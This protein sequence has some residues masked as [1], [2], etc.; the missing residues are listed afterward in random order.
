MQHYSLDTDVN[1][2]GMTEKFHR[3]IYGGLKGRIRLAV[4][5][6]DVRECCPAALS[7]AG[8]TPLEILDAGCGSAPFSL[9]FCGRGHSFTLC[10][11][12]E[13]MMDLA[14]E[15]AKSR[16]ADKKRVSDDSPEDTM[17]SLTFRAQP[18][19]SLEKKPAYDLI[20][21]HALLEWVADGQAVVKHLV[22]ML[23][24]GGILSLAFYNYHALVFQH[25]LWGNYHNVREQS[26]QGR[27]GNL[28]PAHPRRPEEVLAWIRDLAGHPLELL[29]RSGIRVFHDYSPDPLK[30]ETAPDD[31]VAL[32]LAF[33]RRKPYRDM[34][35]YQHLVFIKAMK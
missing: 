31:V 23:R 3:R 12:S 29:C 26:F 34:G 24:P 9:E 35:R 13:E 16:N 20:L 30:Q 8:D 6:R 11:I 1:F 18:I 10:D 2:N 22:G 19:Q 14:R 28:T 7:D 17:G 5:E 4:I 25:L 27:K 15:R 32:E 33:S 21:C